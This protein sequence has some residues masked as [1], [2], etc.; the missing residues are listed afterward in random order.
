M[1]CLNMIVKDESHVIER[2]L[3][4]VKPYIDKV[5]ILDTGSTDGTQKVIEEWCSDNGIPCR[6]D[7][8]PF[9]NFADARTRAIQLCRSWCSNYGWALWLD[10]DDVLTVE[11]KVSLK[12][13][14]K[15]GDDLDAYGIIFR[16]GKE[17]EYPRTLLLNMRREWV[18][19]SVVH[20]YAALA[21]G[22]AVN[23][24]L[25]KGVYVDIV[26]GGNRSKNPLKYEHD[27]SVLKAALDT[28]TDPDMM[29]RYLF[30]IAQS[31]NSAGKRGEAIDAYRL[32]AYNAKGRI[33]QEACVSAMNAG[34]LIE[35]DAMERA[36]KDGLPVTVSGEAFALYCNAIE[37]APHRA[38][39][40]YYAA[41]SLRMRDLPTCAFAF[42]D[43]ASTLKRDPRDLL[44]E[45]GV[46]EWQLDYELCVTCVF[47]GQKKRALQLIKRLLRPLNPFPLT[48]EMREELRR[49]NES[50]EAWEG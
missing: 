3:E 45:P 38:E 19:K 8:G 10:A 1:L 13:L 5:H 40:W 14:Y 32:R 36:D 31:L 50:L 41:R 35:V 18:F 28:E 24:R 17:I 4:S 49:F 2:C 25:L 44:S 33:D 12:E 48:D 22:R 47:V 20:E 9:V 16:G 46:Y 42:A 21:D 6:I 23:T 26:G 37:F 27:V 43:Y 29:N 15:Y 11:S 7:E 34:K 39:P 30:L